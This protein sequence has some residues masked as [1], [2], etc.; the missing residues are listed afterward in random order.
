[1]RLQYSGLSLPL[2]VTRVAT[3]DPE[4]AA[5]LYAAAMQTDLLY[6]CLYFH[7]VLC[8]AYDARAAA[9]GIEM[10]LHLITHQN[11]YPMQTHLP[12]QIREYRLFSPLRLNSEQ[13]IR[14]RFD[15]NPFDYLSFCHIVHSMR[16]H[17]S[18]AAHVE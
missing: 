16:I 13:S 6:G 3:N 7:G 9:V 11:F 4:P 18:R 2:L 12:S 5:A 15:Y 8:P 14:K 1:M 17:C 10:Q